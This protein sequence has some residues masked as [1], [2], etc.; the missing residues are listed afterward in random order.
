MDRTAL[1]NAI[2]GSF[3]M[4]L[5]NDEVGNYSTYRYKLMHTDSL[6]NL[7]QDIVMNDR[8]TDARYWADLEHKCR[9]LRDIISE[10]LENLDNP[11]S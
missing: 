3:E 2:L 10:K 1:Y 9:K 8:E 6:I 11:C 5:E 4:E 7:M